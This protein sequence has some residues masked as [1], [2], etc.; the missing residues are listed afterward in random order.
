MVP[1]RGVIWAGRDI[2]SRNNRTVYGAVIAQ[3]SITADNRLT[4]YAL[5]TTP[6][7]VPTESN[8][9]PQVV[10]GGWLE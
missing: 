5:D 10:V 8:P 6:A 7:F 9:V 4:V 1:R 2:D 3:G